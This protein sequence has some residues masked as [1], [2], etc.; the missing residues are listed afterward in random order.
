M[1]NNTYRRGTVALLIALRDGETLPSGR[2]SS[3]ESQDLISRLITNGAVV[4]TRRRSRLYYSVIDTNRFLQECAR[5]SDFLRSLDDA[6]RL[7]SGE[8]YTREEKVRT[9]GDSKEGSIGPSESGFAIIPASN[10]RVVNHGTIF[11]ITPQTGL[12]ITDDGRGLQLPPKWTIIVVEN[13][14]LFFN[15]DW[16]NHVGLTDYEASHCFILKRY[17]Y[18]E[19]V[20]KFLEQTHNK[21]LY[22]P[23]LDLCGVSIYESMYKSRMGDKVRALLPPDYET[24]LSGR[25]V[26]RNLYKEQIDAGYGNT[27]SKELSALLESIHRHHCCYEQEGYCFEL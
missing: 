24:R 18:T 19:D 4:T 1:N 20:M 6:L 23:D 15:H 25:S 12:M 22:F 9:W 5:Q 10:I 7:A 26:N 13:S 2:F 8:E 21:V 17:P 27:S 11:T 14:R 16:L 3:L